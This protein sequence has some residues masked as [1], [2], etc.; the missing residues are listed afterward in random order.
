M[1]STT[2]QREEPSHINAA[3]RWDRLWMLTGISIGTKQT[4][5]DRL[6]QQILD[7]SSLRLRSVR[8]LEAIVT[9]HRM[10]ATLREA[11]FTVLALR[12][13]LTVDDE[14]AAERTRQEVSTALG[15]S[16]SQIAQMEQ[17]AYDALRSR[18]STSFPN[19]ERYV[20]HVAGSAAPGHNES[21]PCAAGG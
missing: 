6:V 1:E 5:W 3:D 16:V 15:F 18:L 19:I 4:G 20:H 21:T 13:G 9:L 10:L 12:L 8:R 11:H 7:D 2:R 14:P 17:E